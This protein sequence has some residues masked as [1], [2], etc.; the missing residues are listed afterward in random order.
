MGNRDELLDLVDDG[1]T[2]AVETIRLLHGETAWGIYYRD[3]PEMRRI[4]RAMDA[5]HKLRMEEPAD[6]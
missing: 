6:E 4:K 5:V 3:A 1:L 2:A